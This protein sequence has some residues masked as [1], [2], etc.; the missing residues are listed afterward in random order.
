MPLAMEVINRG[1]IGKGGIEDVEFFCPGKTQHV[2]ISIFY[3]VQ[4]RECLRKN[5]LYL[6]MP[7]QF[8]LL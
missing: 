3:Q 7:K 2:L 8:F 5:I 6:V 1:H 4:G